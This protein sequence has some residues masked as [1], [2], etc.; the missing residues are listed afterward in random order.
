M[1]LLYTWARGKETVE[2]V[3]AINKE[4]TRDEGSGNHRRHVAGDEKGTVVR[5]K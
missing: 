3:K 5:V 2:K 1:A 4:R